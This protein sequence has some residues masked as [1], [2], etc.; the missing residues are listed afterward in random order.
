MPDDVGT[1]EFGELGIEELGPGRGEKIPRPARPPDLDPKL[2]EVYRLLKKC[3]KQ[4]ERKEWLK[5]RRECWDAVYKSVIWT[6]KQKTEMELKGMVP[7]T[8]ND[9]YKGVQGSA[10]II[11]DQK[12]GVEFLPVGSGDLYVAELMKRAHD[13]VWAQ[14][15]GGTEIFELVRESKV[16]GLGVVDVKHDPA[17]GI[18]GKLVFGHFDPEL[19]Y[20]DMKKAQK[21]DLSGVSILKAQLITRTQAKENYEDVKDEDLNFAGTEIKDIPDKIHDY[22]TGE[23]NYAKSTDSPAGPDD[24]PEE[25]E[26]VWEIEAHLLKRELEYWLMVPNEKG[27]FGRRTFAKDNKTDA[28][29]A[30][31]TAKQINPNVVL[32]KRLVE[33]RYL[34]IVVGKKLIPQSTTNGPVDELVNP[35]GVDVDGDP[36]LP[37]IVLTHDKTRKGVPVSPTTFAIEACRERNKRRA[38]AIYVTTKNIDAP[39]VVAG[40]H[41]WVKDPVHGDVMKI[42]KTSPF[43]PTRLLPGTITSEALNL[44]KVAKE[45]I[46]DIYDMQDVMKGKIPTGDPSGRTILAL[47]DMAGMMSKPFIRALESSIVRFGKVNMAIILKTWPRSMW[48]RL[49]EEDEWGNWIPEKERKQA[50]PMEAIGGEESQEPN[51]DFIREKWTKALELIRPVDQTK[52]P[53]ISLLDID[54]RVAAGSTLPTNRMAKAAM[55]MDLVKAGIYDAQAALDYVDDPKKDQIAER[56][57]QKEQ[58]MLAAGMAKQ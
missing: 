8:I 41:K 30:F 36:V 38:Q 16:G 50:N 31:A 20:Y 24:M 27:E 21:P 58:A 14:N 57:K 42:E 54:V 26:E 34:R 13:Q 9:L 43:M 33:K 10:A 45:D 47:Q 23:D 25:K 48:E 28:E 19:L 7:L 39:I 15:D 3:L 53:G 29:T 12:P 17:K 22:K 35:Y 6:E 51:Q 32:W 2:L 55:A 4:P 44:E 37:V 49:I 40:E 5:S 52:E 18:Y 46:N 56:M 1:S 11:T